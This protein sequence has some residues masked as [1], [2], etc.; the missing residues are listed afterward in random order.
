MV[1]LIFCVSTSVAVLHLPNVKEI[2]I[3]VK[4][5]QLGTFDMA[6]IADES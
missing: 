4:Y 2:K 3:V 6:L 1:L 5:L